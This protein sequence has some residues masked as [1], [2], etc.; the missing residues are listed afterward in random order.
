MPTSDLACWPTILNEAWQHRQRHHD[1]PWSVL[2]VGPGRGKGAGLIREYVDPAAI[3]DGVEAEPRYLDDRYF[4]ACAYDRLLVGQDV[5]A[6]TQADLA[7]YDLVLMVDVIEH[8]EL[9]PAVSLLQRIPGCIVVCTPSTWFQ[10][11]EAAQGWP[12]EEHKSLWTVHHFTGLGFTANTERGG[13]IASRRA[14]WET[15]I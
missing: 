1:G 15:H 4:P 12:T 5:L 13:I 6:M 2:D 8:L 7:E 9:D 3:I 11:P 10:N 14:A